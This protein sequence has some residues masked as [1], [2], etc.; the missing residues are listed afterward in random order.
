MKMEGGVKM[1]GGWGGRKGEDGSGRGGWDGCGWKK[2][3]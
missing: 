1:G 3:N 2:R